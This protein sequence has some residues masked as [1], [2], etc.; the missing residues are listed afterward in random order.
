MGFILDTIK[1]IINDALEGNKSQHPRIVR[2][3][4]SGDKTY[5]YS[6]VDIGGYKSPSGGYANYALYLVD[7]INPKTNRKNTNKEYM[8]KDEADVRE[9]IKADGYEEILEIRLQQFEEPTENQVN[10]ARDLCLKY[11]DDVT[12]EDLSAILSRHLDDDPDSP[13]PEFAK[14]ADE[15]GFCFSRFI[16]FNSLLGTVRYSLPMPE[17]IALYA[18]AVIR[19]EKKQKVFD[20]YS[21]NWDKLV[22]IGEELSKDEKVTDSLLNRTT[23][24]YLNPNR[25]TTVYKAVYD[26]ILTI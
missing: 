20:P 21:S 7:V 6:M 23:P 3:S 9:K 18:Y 24:D 25:G 5:K 1:S 11:P 8:G 17:K 16:G 2:S 10:Y 14:F 26:K 4:S 19:Q 22:K 15:H 12:K 13:S